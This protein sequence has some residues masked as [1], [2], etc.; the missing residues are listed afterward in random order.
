MSQVIGFIAT[1]KQ[2]SADQGQFWRITT[3]DGQ[4]FTGRVAETWADGV[5]LTWED[6]RPDGEVF[7]TIVTNTYVA[8]SA[9]VSVQRER[10]SKPS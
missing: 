5:I 2:E 6:E 4:V 10:G 7:R 9:I 1:A 3:L 8:P